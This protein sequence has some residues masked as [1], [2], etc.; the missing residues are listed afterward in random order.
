MY[1]PGIVISFIDKKNSGYFCIEQP[2][3]LALNV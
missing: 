3:D 1:W 2:M